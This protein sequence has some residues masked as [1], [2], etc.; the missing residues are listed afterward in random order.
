MFME[1]KKTHTEGVNQDH[2]N[3]YLQGWEEEATESEA[4]LL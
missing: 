3:G 2:K 1:K 4:R